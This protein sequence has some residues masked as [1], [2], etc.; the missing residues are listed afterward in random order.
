MVKLFIGNLN[1]KSDS[2]ELR[3]KFEAYGTVTECDIVNN[4]GFVVSAS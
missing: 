4:Y 2:S 3:Q 1:P